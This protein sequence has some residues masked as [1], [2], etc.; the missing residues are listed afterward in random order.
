MANNYKTA[1]VNWLAVTAVCIA[2]VMLPWKALTDGG[3]LMVA[4]G[5]LGPLYW[6]LAL[7]WVACVI[8]LVR[9]RKHLWVLI[10][11]PVVFYPVVVIGALLNSCYNGN[12]L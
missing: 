3:W 9:L 6:L 8:Y 2:A 7:I 10:T 4:L 12:C 11:A 1:T 5:P